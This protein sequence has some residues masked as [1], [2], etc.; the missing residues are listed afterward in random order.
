M[1]E[2]IVI[3]QP[4]G[5]DFSGLHHAFRCEASPECDVRLVCSEEELLN[6]VGDSTR[7][8]LVVAPRDLSHVKY[9]GLEVLRRNA[10]LGNGATPVVVVADQ[11]D[12]ESAAKAIEAGA[13]D[14][15]VYSEPMRERVATLL[16]KL[17]SL[18][19]AIDQNRLLDERN[20]E[21]R[22]A[23]EAK[24]QLVGDSPQLKELL[25][26]IRRVAVAPRPILISGERGTGKELVALAIHHASGAGDRPI[27]SVNCAAFSDALLESELFGHQRGAFTGAEETRRGKFEQ[28]EN[29]TLFLDEIGHMSLPFQQKILR[30]VEYGAYHRVGG[31][32][33]LKTSARILAATNCDLKERIRQN[34]F[35]PDLYDR[36]TFETLKVPPLRERTGDIEVLAQYFLDQFAREIPAFAGKTLSKQALEVLKRQPFPG[37]VRELKNVIERSAYRDTTG[38]IT[39]NDL[40]LVNDNAMFAF[41]GSFQEK[42]AAFSRRI[43]QDA[44]QESQGNQAAAARQMGLTYHQFRYYLKKHDIAPTRAGRQ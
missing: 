11:G 25:H 23:I 12:V 2:S 22:A 26:R 1:L 33:E 13:T 7:C 42:L 41:K 32:E 35:L 9:D 43:L 10:L 34:K 21:L 16:G 14:F 15:V 17:R 20:E 6:V 39:P 31:S 38:Q 37:N 19:A 29:G 28:A 36:I 3:L 18:Y 44:L 30:V 8:H 24:F 4:Q 40:G 5:E 27:V